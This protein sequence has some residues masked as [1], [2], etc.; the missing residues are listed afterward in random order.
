MPNLPPESVT[1]LEVLVVNDQGVIT[2]TADEQRYTATCSSPSEPS[3]KE[4]DELRIVH[5]GP[6]SVSVQRII[7][8]Q[9][10]DVEFQL[11]FGD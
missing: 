9:L 1:L 2:L 11:I 4:G 10:D 5:R 6:R 3:L 8:G 7:R